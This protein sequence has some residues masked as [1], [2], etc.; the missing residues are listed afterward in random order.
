MPPR[1]PHHF[2]FPIPSNNSFLLRSVF[3]HYVFCLFP[4]TPSDLRLTCFLF[5]SCLLPL[6]PYAFFS[7]H[8]LPFLPYVFWFFPLP[9]M[10][11]ALRRL[12]FCPFNCQN[13]K[14]SRFLIPLASVLNTTKVYAKEV[15]K[16]LRAFF[17]S[18]SLTPLYPPP[19]GGMWRARGFG[20]V[21]GWEQPPQ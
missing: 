21:V 16:L 19:I 14:A 1:V 17:S 6:I 7:P 10:T 2:R 5:S 3:S 18:K 12:V 15:F 9:L 11:Y 20:R 4:F 13:K 8:T